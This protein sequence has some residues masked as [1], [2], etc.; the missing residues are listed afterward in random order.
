MHNAKKESDGLLIALG[1]WLGLIILSVGMFLILALVVWWL[2]NDYLVGAISTVNKI[3][4]LQ[5]AAILLLIG[6]LVSG[7][8]FQPIVQNCRRN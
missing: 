4:Y 8:H 5:S 6:L 3:G 2:W 7:F 1:V